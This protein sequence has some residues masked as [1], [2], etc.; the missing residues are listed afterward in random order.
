MKGPGPRGDC[1]S[2][3][4]QS[5]PSGMLTQ[6]VEDMNS[7]SG[8][9]KLQGKWKITNGGKRWWRSVGAEAGRGRA[10]AGGL[11]Q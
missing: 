1:P 5:S 11:L 4:A 3:G 8:G 7:P 2:L 10:D 6:E 9:I